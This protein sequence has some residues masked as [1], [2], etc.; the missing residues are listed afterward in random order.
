MIS[1]PDDPR[2]HHVSASLDSPTIR[3]DIHESDRDSMQT[4][5]DTMSK[6]VLPPCVPAAAAATHAPIIN[7]RSVSMADS[8]VRPTATSASTTA[9]SSIVNDPSKLSNPIDMSSTTPPNRNSLAN[10]TTSLLP[11]RE[12]SEAF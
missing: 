9:V 7:F 8:T 4:S 1:K 10:E 6:V 5:Q 2:G 12:N 11:M 3:P